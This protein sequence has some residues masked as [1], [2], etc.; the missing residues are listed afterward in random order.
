MKKSKVLKIS[1]IILIFSLIGLFT[2]CMNNNAGFI[3]KKE[4]IGQDIGDNVNGFVLKDKKYN[5]DIDSYKLLFEH[6][7]TGAKLVVIKN[8]DTNKGFTI[9]FNTPAESNKGIP[10]ITEHSLLSGSKKYPGNDILFSLYNNT[11]SSYVNG[12]IYANLIAYPVCSKSEEQLMKSTDVYLDSVYNPLVAQDKRIFDREAWRYE[13]EDEKSE[14]GVNGT[15]YNEVKANYS[16]IE[17]YQCMNDLKTIFCDTNQQYDSGG[18]PE[19]ILDLSYDEFLEEYNKKYTPSNS[20]MVLY[21][22]INYEKFLK[23]IDENYLSSYGKE[24]V[25]LNRV[26]QKESEEVKEE[27]YYFPVGKDT[28]TTNKSKIDV[29]FALPDSIKV[30][31]Q[32]LLALETSIEQLNDNSSEFMKKLNES[33]IAESY[34]ISLVTGFYQPIVIV[35]ANNADPS[36]KKEFYNVVEQA[37]KEDAYKSINKEKAKLKLDSYKFSNLLDKETA[38]H[39]IMLNV[40]NM[41]L[42]FNDPMTDINGC[43]KEV[44]KKVDE[45][46]LEDTINKYLINNKLKALVTTIPKAGLLEEKT[47]NIEERLKNKKAS[48]SQEEIKNIIEETKQFKEWNNQEQDQS[49]IDSIKAVNA[50]DINIEAQKNKISESDKS[51]VKVF[52]A[53]T[54]FN[55]AGKIGFIFDES[56]LSKEELLYLDFYKDILLNSMPSHEYSK[57]CADL[58]LSLNPIRDNKEGTKAHPV[59]ELSYYAMNEDYKNILNLSEKTLLTPPKNISDYIGQTIISSKTNFEQNLSNPED[60]MKKRTKAYNSMYYR[61]DSYLNGLEY[62]K[63]VTDLGKKYEKNPEEVI[64]KIEE[65]Q[66]KAFNKKDLTVLYAGNSEGKKQFESN[67]DSFI[68]NVPDKVYTKASYELPKPDKKEAIIIDSDV[69][70]VS[71]NLGL[72]DNAK[73]CG[74]LKVLSTVLNDQFLIPELRLKGGAYNVE[75]KVDECNYNI[76]IGRV[77]NYENSLSIIKEMDKLTKDKLNKINDKILD[78]YKVATLATE[79]A[80]EGE[81]TKAYNDIKKEIEDNSILD[82]KELFDEIKNVKVDDIKNKNTYLKELKDNSNYIVMG[83]KSDIEKSED[84]FDKII[85]L[86]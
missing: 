80:P 9:G 13:L 86:N 55:T 24:K 70:Y 18:E 36:K 21:G 78:N 63:F 40:C 77:D 48:M 28:D 11:Y 85:E 51:G 41:N 76:I 72:K 15:V 23:M 25:N 75:G 84:K 42:I 52:Y 16:N 38:A 83:S 35:D 69:Q 7:K 58:N 39:N 37:I 81:L 22:D 32:D 68:N 5:K 47:A 59:F 61:Y 67:L 44:V 56:H 30:G 6:V 53:D 26:E 73:N 20:I 60:F 62:Y 54:D 65:V 57:Y 2:V 1:L 29:V 31:P 43:Y 66:S 27:E 82:R 12:K 46:Y 45:G 49:I 74:Q 71:I 10:H 19:S 33:G 3:K 8:N 64:K 14:L 34:E 79:D 50:K 17:Y 4:V